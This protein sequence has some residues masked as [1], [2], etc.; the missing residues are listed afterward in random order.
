MRLIV[1]PLT[2]LL[3]G[4]LLLGGTARAADPPADATPVP[5]ESAPSSVPKDIQVAKDDLVVPYALVCNGHD[6]ETMLRIMPTTTRVVCDNT[7]TLAL[8]EGRS[9]RHPDP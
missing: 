3:M 4:S 9:L 1:L 6:G 5:T 7:L 2:A 8:S